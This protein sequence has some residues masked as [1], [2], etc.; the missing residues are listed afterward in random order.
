MLRFLTGLHVAQVHV[1]D[2]DVSAPR[3]CRRGR[4][5]SQPKGASVSK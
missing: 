2:G 5:C 1:A 3:R 4:Q